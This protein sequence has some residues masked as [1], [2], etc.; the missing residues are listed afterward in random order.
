MAG[1]PSSPEQRG[2]VEAILRRRVAVVLLLA[3]AHLSQVGCTPPKAGR[4][5]VHAHERVAFVLHRLFVHATGSVWLE[6]EHFGD[7]FSASLK[8]NLGGEGAQRS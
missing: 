7:K 3:V 8:W 2:G 6:L 5:D 1:V 4:L